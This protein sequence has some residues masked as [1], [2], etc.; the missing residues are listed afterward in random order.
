MIAKRPDL[1]AERGFSM[2]LVIMAMLLTAMFVAAAFAAANG[3]LPISGDS[4]DRKVSY[5]AAEGGLN[6][7]LNHLQ[8]DNDYWTKCADVPAP[9]ATENNP[10]SQ[11]YDGVGVDKRQWRNVPGTSA[12]YTIEL[13]H[14]AGYSQCETDPKKQDSLIDLSTGTFKIRVTGRPSATSTQRRSI[15]ATFRRDGFLNF[16][17][18]TDYEGFDP[19]ANSSASVRTWA[20]ANCA[21][22]Y[23][24][25]R[26][27]S[28]LEIQFA[29]QDALRGP[30]HSNDDSLL[31]CGTPEFGRVDHID[32]VEVTGGAPGYV[33]NGGSCAGDPVINTPTNLF[34]TSA[35]P[36]E[37]PSS[38]QSLAD[39][40]DLDG[41]SFQGKTIVRL[42][43]NGLMDITN[44]SATGVP[45]T[46]LD[47]AW[48]N[49]GVL[50]V[51][52]NGPCNG[53]YP[54]AA[55]YVEPAACGNVYVSGTYS[56]SLT[57][58]AA[59]DV[60]IR[61]TLGGKLSNKSADADLK[62]LAGSDATLGLIANN[63]VRVAHM[64]STS[65][66]TCNGNVN[67]TNDPIFKDVQVDAAILSLQHSFIADNYDCGRLGTLTVNGA[68]AQ[69]YRG[70]VGTGSGS[71]V[72]T[73]FVKNYNYDDRFRYRS[74]PYFLNP[75]DS[76]W[77]VIRS[78]EQVPAAP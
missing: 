11:Q 9:N 25:A 45:T 59:N 5:A 51:K 24:S 56:R 28:C 46:Q 31:V 36:M 12:Q 7:Y 21:D 22:K 14:T 41:L 38:N 49:N 74:P 10:V 66:N 19:Q 8:Q 54:T 16:I 58:A 78:H 65:G 37:M 34:T 35:K 60:I 1:R 40:A 69:K 67:T 2:F 57:I 42:K 3:D 70:T 64:V 4:R 17:Y 18:F 47:A 32:T 43:P 72:L 68:I 33:K 50:Y 30:V 13:L 26:N 76:A 77:D 61:P 15:V 20:Q 44:Y 39:I 55:N 6:F 23:R 71:T 53:E 27:S 48:P 75:I 73:G 52:N 62:R 29:D 63:F